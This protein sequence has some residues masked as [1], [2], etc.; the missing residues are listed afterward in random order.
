M[1]SHSPFFVQYHLVLQVSDR[2]MPIGP[3]T[4]TTGEGRQALP[5]KAHRPEGDWSDP[6]FSSPD[7]VS[8]PVSLTDW[9]F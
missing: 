5:Q 8:A 9:G 4:G 6:L 1:F 3:E 7:T 2:T